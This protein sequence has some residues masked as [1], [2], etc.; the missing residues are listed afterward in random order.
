MNAFL[1]F[2]DEGLGIKE[3]AWRGH[4]PADSARCHLLIRLRGWVQGEEGG[5][6]HLPPLPVPPG[7]ALQEG[8]EVS[9]ND[10]MTPIVSVPFM[11]Q[12]YSC[13]S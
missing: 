9:T 3:P 10:F 13:D 11:T 6:G 12:V 7:L 1:L 4:I 5:G 8:F 2:K